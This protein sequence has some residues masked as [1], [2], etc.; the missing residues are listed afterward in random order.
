MQCR[1]DLTLMPKFF[2]GCCCAKIVSEKVGQSRFRVDSI[3]LERKRSFCESG[4]RLTPVCVRQVHVT[5]PDFQILDS[6][7]FFGGCCCAK[8]VSEK[9]GQSRF[10][11]DSIYL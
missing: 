1:F 6:S 11:V 4:L 2:G 7:K 8:I 9:V 5:G 10:R 3:H